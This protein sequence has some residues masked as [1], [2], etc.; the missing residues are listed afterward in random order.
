MTND[1]VPKSEGMRSRPCPPPVLLTSCRNL[2]RASFGGVRRVRAL[3]EALSPSAVICQPRD[4]YPGQDTVV[5][6]VDLGTRKRGINWGIFNFAW[7]SN[8]RVV[9]RALSDRKPAVIVTTSM[10]DTLAFPRGMTTP[11]I[12]DA[13][14]VEVIAIAERYGERHPFTR[15]VAR[16]EGRA[17]REAVHV[18]ACSDVDR[19]T[20]VR[21][22]GIAAEKIT[23]VPNG[24]DTKDA[25]PT[26]S[27]PGDDP[28]AA[29]LR[30]RAILFFMGKLDY[31]PN[32][33]A[34]DILQRGVLPELERIAPG[35][36][37]LLVCGGP[38]PPSA[39]HSS[40]V[41]AGYVPPESLRRYLGSAAVCLAPILSGS[42]TRL[43]IL[44]YMAA[45]KPVVTTAKGAEGITCAD[46]R[47]LVIAAPDAFAPSILR[48]HA[49]PQTAATIGTAARRL[50]EARYDWNRAIKPL[51]REALTRWMPG[52]S[53]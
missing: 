3:V 18:F 19:N 41:F 43:K 7:P 28:L 10:W 9:R 15:L 8:R 11:V 31:Q 16:R 4:A 39:P 48:L 12:Y 26:G 2:S 52:K 53:G 49:N 14:N 32:T 38:V 6:P 46:G 17:L 20:F 45:A 21:R 34:L 47:D 25:P 51:W 35:R 44:E 22:Y 27:V 24:V 40:T 13:Q 5:Y 1:E 36:F 23:V 29:R 30:D 33:E 42:G 37:V 50:V